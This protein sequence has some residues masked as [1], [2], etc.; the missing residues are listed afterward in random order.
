MATYSSTLALKI[1]WMEELGAGYYP[2]GR[3]ELGTTERLH[4]L[5]FLFIWGYKLGLLGTE[6]GLNKPG[7]GINYFLQGVLDYSTD[8]GGTYLLFLG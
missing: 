3:K 7:P 8:T 5:S 6:L 4:F 2:W 1:P